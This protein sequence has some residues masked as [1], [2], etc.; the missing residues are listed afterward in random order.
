[1]SWINT[2][3]CFYNFFD[4]RLTCK[5]VTNIVNVTPKRRVENPC[6]WQRTC[7]VFFPSDLNL[8][9][10]RSRLRHYCHVIV[11]KPSQWNEN[12]GNI[13][14]WKNQIKMLI[15]LNR[16]LV[17][18]CKLYCDENKSFITKILVHSPVHSTVAT[19]T[20]T[21]GWLLLT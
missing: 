16:F 3:I 21:T 17:C 5:I 9:K 10:N 6:D 15:K 13:K 11:E 1:M 19:T 7:L 18:I 12:S 2:N 14:E 20:S 4:A 8:L